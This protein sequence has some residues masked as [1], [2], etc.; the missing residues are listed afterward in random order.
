MLRSR[1]DS[2]LSSIEERAHRL[3]IASVKYADLSVKREGEYR[4]SP[5]KM[6]S[7][8][9]NTAPYLLYVLVRIR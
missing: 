2:Q 6:T 3:G 5:Q 1:S 8:S 7:M 9:G 4:F